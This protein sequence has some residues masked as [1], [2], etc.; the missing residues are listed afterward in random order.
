MITSGTVKLPI[1]DTNIE[2]AYCIII[3]RSLFHKF[4]VSSIIT[5][6]LVFAAEFDF[7]S[8]GRITLPHEVNRPI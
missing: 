1:H 2:K 3:D 7:H 5:Q 8:D 6:L 4:A